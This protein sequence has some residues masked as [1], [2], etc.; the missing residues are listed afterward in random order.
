MP[1]AVAVLFG[2]LL[3]LACCSALGSLLLRRV[4]ARLYR[5]EERLLGLVCGASLLHLLVF[6]LCALQL[7][8]T[9]VFLGLGAAILLLGWRRGAFR[10]S[11]AP[12]FPAL[13]RGSRWLAGAVFSAYAFL[14]GMN[15]LAPEMSPDGSTY[16]LGLVARTLREHGLGRIT[17]NMYANLPQGVEMLYL[18]AFA[19]G[20]HSAA[21]LVH[22]GFT[23]ALPLL[24]L[25]YGRRFGLPSA[26]LCAGL[27]VLCSPV[28]GVA[29]SSAYN[30]VAVSCVVFATFTLVRI[31]SAER[32]EG[33]L[34]PM[35][36][37]AGY[38]LAAKYTAAPALL[39]AGAVVL[40]KAVRPGTRWLRPVA[41]FAACVALMVVPWLAK[42]WLVVGNPL[43]P[44]ANRL[45]PNP[46]VRISFEREYVEGMRR[47]GD[48]KSAWEVPFDLT[49]RGARLGGLLGPV[50]VLAP[51]ALLATRRREGRRL[52]LAA[53]VFALPYAN[54]IGTRFLLPSLPLLSLALAL[55]LQPFRGGLPALALAHAVLSWPSVLGLYSAPHAWRLEGIPVAAA[56]GWLPEAEVLA[57]RHP[58]YVVARMLEEFVP[59]GEKVFSYSGAADAYTSREILVAYQSGFNTNLAEFLFAALHA[60]SAPR[61]GLRFDFAERPLRGLRLV[62]TGEGDREQWSVAEWRILRGERELLRSPE[63]RLRADPNPWDVQLAFD[64]SPVTR[65]RS[66]QALSPGMFLEVDLGAERRVDGALVETLKGRDG[67]RVRLYGRRERGD[68]ALLDDEP[69]ASDLP[70]AGGLRRAAL[71]EFRARGV[72]YLLAAPHDPI[73]EDLRLK[74]RQWGIRLLAERGGTRLYA[75]DGP[76]G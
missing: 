14:Y 35:G 19:F 74:S 25:S 47:F 59:P 64:N 9:G 41:T 4:G 30:D 7:A 12:T 45:F 49:V 54:N 28:V 27:L 52:L 11:S 2:S 34:V 38:C 70:A 43:S 22:L 63:W 21:S 72:R 60:D 53:A 55:A 76:P 8:R 24:V 51:L 50:F 39:Y 66:W 32:R 58:G 67:G 40:G 26:G 1:R 16:H 20:R 75:I 62:Q 10:R 5:D 6:A 3:T 68:W 17:T 36:L 29:G 37:L 18:F 46:N 65:W 33:L 31:W 71:E 15:A 57:A 13:G 73:A 44:F 42:N 69:R 61:Q 48:P 23:L 56:L